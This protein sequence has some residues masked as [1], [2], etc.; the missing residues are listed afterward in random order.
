M[1]IN[2][3][4]YFPNIKTTDAELKGFKNLYGNALNNTLP[5]FELT[6]SRIS[7]KNAHGRISKRVEN[8]KE[9]M[10]NRHFIID[11]TGHE[12]LENQEIR[13]LLK[14]DNGYE[15]W[16]RFLDDFDN[17]TPVIHF[18]IDD[19]EENIEQQVQV[20]ENNFGEVCVRINPL[21]EEDH[22]T[23]V[24][25]AGYMKNPNNL[26]VILDV[27]YMANSIMLEEATN[28]AS[29]AVSQISQQSSVSNYITMSSSFPNS[30]L[31]RGGQDHYGKFSMLETQLTQDIIN[32]SNGKNIKHG[33]YASVHPVR[34]P[35]GGGWVPRGD[36]PLYDSY[37]YH[38]YRSDDGGYVE[39][40]SY[41]LDDSK[42]E[43]IG[44]W[45]DE[46]IAQAANG[47]PNGISP[48]HWI[49]VRLNI[50]ITRQ[51]T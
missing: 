43:S 7:K 17:I 35:G 34:Y 31:D 6:R 12:G 47:S 24:A 37:F 38:R 11:V 29:Y 46:E 9:I 8:I 22:E 1:S 48:S 13:N 27:E 51:A 18:G 44:S 49:A 10:G 36:V 41:V 40:A 14:E 19:E 50:H 39:A 28:A 16:V 3:F 4:K 42:Y 30:V 5:I 26:W 15:N 25:I 23:V 20:L 32:V 2:K 21:Y 45:G 33:D